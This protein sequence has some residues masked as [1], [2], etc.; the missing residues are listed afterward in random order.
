MDHI[1]GD[2]Y[3]IKKYGSSKMVNRLYIYQDVLADDALWWIIRRTAVQQTAG[4]MANWEGG[5]W[6]KVKQRAH[7]SQKML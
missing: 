6:Q 1:F 5:E 3:N 7:T 4:N 2:I